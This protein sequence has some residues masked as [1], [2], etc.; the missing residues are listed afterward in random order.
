MQSILNRE[1]IAAIA[2]PPGKAG[3]GIIRIS[4]NGMQQ[5]GEGILGRLP[6]PRVATFMPFV[7]QQGVVIDQG[8]ALF[9]PSPNSYT[10]ED[11]LELQGHGGR[12]V[13]NM[14]LSRVLEL[15]ARMANPGEFTERAFLNNKMDLAQ[16]EAVA[17]LV[18]ATTEQAVRSARNSLEGVFSAF[19]HELVEE[20]I[21]IRLYVESSIDFVEEEID[22][23][24]D[25]VVKKKID[26][27]STQIASILQTAKQGCL[28]RDGMTVV[29]A[30]KPNTGKSSLLNSLAGKETAIVTDQAG[31]TRDVL[32]ESIQID[33]L[34]LHIVDTA[35]LR[36]S[37]ESI[38][39]EGMRRA[40]EEIQNADQILWMIDARELYED[41]LMAPVCKSHQGLVRIFNKI[42]LTDHKPNLRQ[43]SNETDIF[44]SVK[45]GSGMEYLYAYL[46]H[47]VG[48]N[49][50]TENV[51]S[52]RSRHIDSLVTAQ[53][54]I[55]NATVQLSEFKAGELVAEE[56]RV[57]QQ[58][59][60]LITGEFS[61]DDLLGRIF[62]SFCIGK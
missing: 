56:L 55:Q 33:G 3:V 29:I 13:L 41:S 58:S 8:I 12:V 36:D 2:T 57:A 45:T 11:V 27:L 9:F 61:N 40:K 30:G 4:G 26:N 39:Q 43:C 60:S 32:R 15:G 7:D 23:L 35:G 14:L 44:L 18:Q 20:L 52:A 22:F 16:A 31:T 46:K 48:Y 24:S 6:E 59:L 47:S 34:P 28:L 1:P 37:N 38:E 25:G 54:C 21:E 5:L 62:S 51:F 17:D 50:Q 10:G 53:T 42:D 49:D 19:I